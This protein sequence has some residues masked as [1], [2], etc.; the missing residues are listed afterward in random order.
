MSRYKG[1][2]ATGAEPE[3][4]RSAATGLIAL[5]TKAPVVTDRAGRAGPHPR[6]HRCAENIY[7]RFRTG[8]NVRERWH[9]F[10]LL[11]GG[12][13][14]FGARKPRRQEDGCIRLRDGSVRQGAVADGS[15]TVR[16]TVAGGVSHHTH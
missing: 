11:R 12:S 7:E 3:P 9:C 15:G 5:Q 6:V 8:A 1:T 4:N 16:S 14:G 13:I 10:G 2:A